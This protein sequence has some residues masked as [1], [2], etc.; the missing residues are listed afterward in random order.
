MLSDDADSWVC[1]ILKISFNT[2]ALRV[3]YI[4]LHAFH[5]DQHLSLPDFFRVFSIYITI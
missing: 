2:Y 1:Y 5:S 4:L 3:A